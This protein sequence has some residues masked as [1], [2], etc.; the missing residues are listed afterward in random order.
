MKV[1]FIEKEAAVKSKI[2]Q[3]SKVNRVS[4]FKERLNYKN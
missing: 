2:W 1:R 3:K 4:N